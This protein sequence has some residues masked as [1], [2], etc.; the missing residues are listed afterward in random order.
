MTRLFEVFNVLLRQVKAALAKISER[1]LK[2]A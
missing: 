1:M 2:A